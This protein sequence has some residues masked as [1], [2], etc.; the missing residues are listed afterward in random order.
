MKLSPPWESASR[1]ATQ[2]LISILWYPKV[3][4]RVHKGALP[5]PI[6]SQIDPVH[7]T[8]SYLKSI[9]IL[10]TNLRLGLP[11]GLAPSGF[12][13]NILHAFLFDPIRATCPAH[14]ILEFIILRNNTSRIV[15]A[16][17]LPLHLSS[18]QIFS[19]DTKFHTHTEP[20][21]KLQ[22]C[23][24]WFLCF[25]AEDEKTEGSGLNGS[26]HFTRIQSPINFLLN[27]VLICYSCSL[28]FE[29]CHIFETSV[30]YLYVVILPCNLA[31]R[32]Q[33]IHT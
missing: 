15:Q 2:E 1:A 21:A 5:V 23:I 3:H 32:Q 13:T 29:L 20:M 4:Y 24:F 8:P 16:M 6:L 17:K 33:H 28:I 14:L 26:K 22:F 11:C 10:S 9:L 31:K 12:L 27:Q 18:V 25:Q 19:S 7:T 30:I